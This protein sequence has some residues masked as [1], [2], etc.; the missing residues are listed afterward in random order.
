MQQ[1][2]CSQLEKIL[3]DHEPINKQI[4]LQN[5]ELAQREKEVEKREARNED[6]RRKLDFEKK[7]NE[8]ATLEQKI[9]DENLLRLAEDQQDGDLELKKKGDALQQDLAEKE[10]ELKDLESLSQALRVKERKSNDEVQQALKE[11]INGLTGQSSRATI[12]IKRMGDLDSKPF[13][14]AAKR[15]YGK[16]ADSK[17]MELCSLWDAYLRDPNWHPFKII[18]GSDEE[19]GMDAM[20]LDVLL[21]N[22]VGKSP[23]LFIRSVLYG[24]LRPRF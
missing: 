3:E 1:N 22:F 9:A 5:K 12:G 16:E 17:A 13:Y 18:R 20:S 24:L 15:K 23:K 8:R 19:E 11:L 21:S 14:I 6:E 2:A 10:Q 4:E 7:M